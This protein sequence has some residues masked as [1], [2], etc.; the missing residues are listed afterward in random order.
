M[1]TAPVAPE[2]AS[3]QEGATQK[4]CDRRLRRQTPVRTATAETTATSSFAAPAGIHTLK[5]PTL[6]L[7]SSS[8]APV[9][10]RFSPPPA[11]WGADPVHGLPGREVKALMDAGCAV[12]KLPARASPP[13]SRPS[14]ARSALPSGLAVSAFKGAGRQPP[15]G[16][17]AAKKSSRRARAPAAPIL[18][19][20]GAGRAWACGEKAG[21]SGPGGRAFVGGGFAGA[22]RGGAWAVDPKSPRAAGVC[23]SRLPHKHSGA[24]QVTKVR[25]PSLG[26]ALI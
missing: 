3:P 2:P 19:R 4:G 21:L 17:Q 13:G 26:P 14:R 24:G 22:G 5:I 9:S 8:A 6:S 7:P 16:R 15:G 25:F 10:L 11:L 12:P 1:Q 18:D 23:G 20:P